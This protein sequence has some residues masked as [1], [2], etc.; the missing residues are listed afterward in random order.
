METVMKTFIISYISS[1]LVIVFLSF[2]AVKAAPLQI[3]PRIAFY[4]G[5]P[6]AIVVSMVGIALASMIGSPRRSRDAGLKATNGAGE[7]D[8]VEGKKAA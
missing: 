1:V 4:Y 2:P 7:T 3:V 8:L 5:F 6:M